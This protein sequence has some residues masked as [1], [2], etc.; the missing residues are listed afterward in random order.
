MIEGNVHCI[1]GGIFITI[2]YRCLCVVFLILPEP[3]DLVPLQISEFSEIIIK[4]DAFHSDTIY[5][6]T[7]LTLTL[8]DADRMAMADRKGLLR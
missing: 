5:L 3:L 8:N 2:S 7:I 4:G 6:K 1:Y